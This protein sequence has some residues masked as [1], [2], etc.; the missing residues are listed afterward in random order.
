MRRRTVE[1]EVIFLDV[2]AVIAFAIG[3]PEET[4][5][6]DRVFPVPKGERKTDSLLL[7]ADPPEP[8][9][10]PAI[11]ARAGVIVGEEI[12]RVTPRTIVLADGPPLTLGQIRAPLL[13][14]LFLLA[15]FFEAE[16]LSS[17]HR[18]PFS[19]DKEL[20]RICS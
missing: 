13:P 10:A 11:G 8:I 19:P 1:V 20:A 3:E 17:L 15:S 6:E 16:M 4:L 9:L 12:P 2:L 5:L 18:T 7:V 14:Q